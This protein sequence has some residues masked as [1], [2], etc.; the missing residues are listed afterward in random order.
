LDEAFRRAVDCSNRLL[1]VIKLK[2]SLG[3]RSVS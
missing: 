1:G 2:A 3:H